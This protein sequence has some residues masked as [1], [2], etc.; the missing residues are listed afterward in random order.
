MRP[1]SCLRKRFKGARIVSVDFARR[2]LEKAQQKKSWW[3]NS[4]F[5]QASAEALPF[6]N[7]SIDVIFSNQLLPWVNDPAAVFSEVARVLR[8]GGVFAFATLG[9]DSFREI[10]RAWRQLDDRPH[11]SAFPDMHDL[12]DSLVSAGLR[13]PV[14][15]VDRLCINTR[16]ADTLMADLAAA[17]ARNALA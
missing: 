7:E 8:K 4:A 2:M 9:P 5:V 1:I 6:A 15:D 10:G 12:G 3:S 13:D 11:V 16:H 14:L 17:G